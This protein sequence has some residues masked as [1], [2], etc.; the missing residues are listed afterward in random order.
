MTL[1][2]SRAARTAR[3]RAASTMASPPPSTRL[4]KLLQGVPFEGGVAVQPHKVALA[5]AAVV[6]AAHDGGVH[7][8]G[9]K[10]VGHA[11]AQVGVGVGVARELRRRVGVAAWRRRGGRG[12]GVGVGVLPVLAALAALRGWWGVGCQ[13]AHAAAVCTPCQTGSQ[14]PPAAA[15]AARGT[16]THTLQH[17]AHRPAAHAR[18]HRVE[19][20]L[21][22][23]QRRRPAAHKNAI[24]KPKR[25]NSPARRPCA[26]PWR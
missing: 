8:G 19:H 24:F 23:P 7:K 16:H 5:G 15:H 12:V 21:D 2:R 11:R 20:A 13:E 10:V 9:H 22:P 4:V 18:C 3:A 1:A 6:L 25:L 17:A 26:M 14:P